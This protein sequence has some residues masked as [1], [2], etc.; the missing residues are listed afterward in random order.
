MRKKG[1]PTKVQTG[2]ERWS[3]A[4]SGDSLRRALLIYDSA[5]TKLVLSI[6]MYFK[7]LGAFSPKTTIKK[8]DPYFFATLMQVMREQISL[9][10]PLH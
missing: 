3:K 6:G 1:E 2:H 8:D 5:I 7:R 10:R 4:L 9:P